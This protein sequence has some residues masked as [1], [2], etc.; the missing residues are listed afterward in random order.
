MSAAAAYS[1]A[2]A[3]MSSIGTKVESINNNGAYANDTY[4]TKSHDSSVQV[5]E[6]AMNN[7]PKPSSV[8]TIPKQQLNQLHHSYSYGRSIPLPIPTK[9][10]SPTTIKK[11]SNS[12]IINSAKGIP[13]NRGNLTIHSLSNQKTSNMTITPATITKG[14]ALHPA[15]P[16]PIAKSGHHQTITPVPAPTPSLI[17]ATKKRSQFGFGGNHIV[18]S[19]P[20]PPTHQKKSTSKTSRSKTTSSSS[21]KRQCNSTAQQTKGQKVSAV[22]ECASYERKKQRAKDAR[23]KL[24]ESIERLA[25]AISLAGTQSKQRAQAHAYWENKNC[26]SA[27]SD[28]TSNTKS[29]STVKGSSIDQNG[30]KSTVEI[31]EEAGKTANG[32][33]KWERP[34]FVGSAAT[35]IQNLNA[36]CEA[37]MRELIEMKKLQN[38]G[39][40]QQ[41]GR[42]VKA[43][44]TG[45]VSDLSSHEEI[46]GNSSNLNEIKFNSAGRPV[47]RAK[48]TQEEIKID[49]NAIVKRDRVLLL[50]GSFLDPRSIV[51]FMC[52]SKAW[53]VQLNPA[54][55]DDS[56]WASLCVK[57]FGAYNFREWLHRHEDDSLILNEPPKP[58]ITLYREMDSCNVKPRCRNEGNCLLGGG[59]INNIACGWVSVVERS[60]GETLRSV[61]TTSDGDVKYTSLP[62]VEMRI[63]VQN[64][65]VADTSI[66]IPEQII[67]VDAS[68]K[69]RGEEFFE[70]NSD[71][72]MRKKVCS[73]HGEEI[74][75][76]AS[77]FGAPGLMGNLTKLKLFDTAVISVYIHAK[78][79]PT[80][81][82]FRLKSNFV[83]V[84]LNV[85]GTTLPLVIPIAQKKKK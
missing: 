43:C 6:I 2:G 78:G 16:I 25:V 61:L 79:C 42:K 28:S 50:I 51:R 32:A 84:L 31:M 71:N 36:Q 44:T 21:R 58:H 41:V 27:I 83:K 53:K 38:E 23:V 66:I 7:T 5:E 12:T 30:I 57:R 24:N 40:F 60:N 39:T 11:E 45:F 76:H 63:I 81:A 80:T 65:G 34:S 9:N 74:D 14:P 22:T 77:P 68:T 75:R 37:L 54:M 70:I 10:K 4:H 64:I 62:I 19:V 72:R 1:N 47:K 20:L 15:Q 46:D 55:T 3:L 26:T 8:S 29:S 52:V 85:R 48:L 13:V 17:E 69:R 82:K 56:I 33:K 73:I 49:M 59:K 18:P 35:I 67:S